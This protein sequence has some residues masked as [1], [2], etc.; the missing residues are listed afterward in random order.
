M[1]KNPLCN[2]K[3]VHNL[4]QTFIT[5]LNV[6]G[7]IKLKNRSSWNKEIN[8]MK[9]KNPPI[10][11]TANKTNGFKHNLKNNE[12]KCIYLIFIWKIDIKEQIW[13]S[14]K[15]IHSKFLTS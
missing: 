15:V 14:Y 11:T 7:V 2:W 12:L 10:G 9:R 4:G 3:S 13:M 1:Q 5:W 8:K 6:W